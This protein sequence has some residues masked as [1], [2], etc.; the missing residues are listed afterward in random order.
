MGPVLVKT[1]PPETESGA[2][3]LKFLGPIMFEA[4]QERELCYEITEIDAPFQVIGLAVPAD[5]KM[6]VF[7]IHDVRRNKASQAVSSNPIPAAVFSELAVGAHL[8]IDTLRYGDSVS[9]VVSNASDASALFVAVLYGI[10]EPNVA[11]APMGPGAMTVAFG[12]AAIPAG[13]AAAFEVELKNDFMPG[14]LIVPSVLGK[15]FDVV[16]LEIGGKPQLAADVSAARLDEHQRQRDANLGMQPA[17]LFRSNA[18]R[19]DKIRLIVRN[20]AASQQTFS[21]ILI[22]AGPP[23]R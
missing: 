15:H 19:G 3:R 17:L 8:G 20:K 12:P 2:P 18:A 6:G 13:N 23:P 1:A 4:G 21:G 11:L 9:I 7:M 14:M 16:Q 22:G 10:T 5:P